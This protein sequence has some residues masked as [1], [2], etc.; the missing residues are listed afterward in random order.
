MWLQ[1]SELLSLEFRYAPYVRLASLGDI[2]FDSQLLQQDSLFG[3]RSGDSPSFEYNVQ[4]G[5]KFRLKDFDVSRRKRR[6]RSR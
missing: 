3:Q 6:R 2:I 4:L 1:V 5:L